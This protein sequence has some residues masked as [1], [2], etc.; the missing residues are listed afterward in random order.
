MK[1]I[2]L[3]DILKD[4]IVGQGLRMFVDGSDLAVGETI[5]MVGVQETFYAEITHKFQVNGSMV[6]QFKLLPTMTKDG[7]AY[8]V[9]GTEPNNARNIQNLIPEHETNTR[10][11]V[12]PVEIPLFDEQGKFVGEI[13]IQGLRLRGDHLGFLHVS[14][15]HGNMGHNMGHLMQAITPERMTTI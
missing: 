7:E 13:G 4:Q 10:M 8:L 6:H 15:R 9:I 5:A 12:K 14:Y 3:H 11:F 2:I 1:S